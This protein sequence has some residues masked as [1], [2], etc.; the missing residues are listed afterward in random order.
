MS[1]QPDRFAEGV[2]A[3]IEAMTSAKWE[4]VGNSYLAFLIERVRALVPSPTQPEADQG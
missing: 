4:G 1:N 3:T 2:E